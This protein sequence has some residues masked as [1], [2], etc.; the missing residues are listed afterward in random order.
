MQQAESLFDPISFG[1]AAAR[2]Y[3][4]VVN[5][6]ATSGRSHRWRVG[7]LLIA[8]V[9]HSRGL[10]LYTRNPDDLVGLDDL[11]TVVTV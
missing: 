9:A 2:S 7:D 6:V 1:R 8:A 11:V 10:H 5:A 3:G 4:L